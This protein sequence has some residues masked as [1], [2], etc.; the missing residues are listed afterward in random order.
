MNC[1]CDT[2]DR[3]YNNSLIQQEVK[4]VSTY[5]L[6][7]NQIVIMMEFFISGSAHDRYIYVHTDNQ[8][9]KWS[10]RTD[11]HPSCVVLTLQHHLSQWMGRQG[12]MRHS[13]IHL[14][15]GPI[16]VCVEC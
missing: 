10:L 9:S 2:T 8:M 1:P 12:A 15:N 4:C 16:R 14:K 11:L 7:I 6:W 3:V 13:P 5:I